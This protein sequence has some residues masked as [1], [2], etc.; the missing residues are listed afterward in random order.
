MTEPTRPVPHPDRDSRPWWDALARH[1]LL[2]QRPSAGRE[3]DHAPARAQLN[4]VEPVVRAQRAF[5]HVHAQQHSRPATERRVVDAAMRIG[6]VLTGIVEPHVDQA[7]LA[8]AAQQRRA[9]WSVEVLRE[10]REHVDAHRGSTS[11]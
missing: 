1:E 8:G 6:G 4:G 11:G 3:R 7:A 10:D 2:L 9:Q 5:D